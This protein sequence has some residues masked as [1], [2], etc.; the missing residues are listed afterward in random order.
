MYDLLSVMKVLRYC[1]V[2]LFSLVSFVSYAQVN[3]FTADTEDSLA[4]NFYQR[5]KQFSVLPVV[6]FPTLQTGFVCFLHNETDRA[7]Y[8]FE[9]KTNVCRRYVI[10]GEECYGEG[11][12]EKE[13]GYNTSSFNIGL[14]RGFTR[15]WFIYGGVGVVIKKTFYDNEVEDSYRY[16]VTNEGVWFNLVVGTMFVTNKNISALAGLDLYDRTVT[17]GV[18][19]TW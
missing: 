2:F 10:E 15:N 8:Y 18:G 13:V 3:F 11:T 5:G 1:F 16:W 17:I 14:G 9:A 6:N 19:Y 7:S 12:R 4:T